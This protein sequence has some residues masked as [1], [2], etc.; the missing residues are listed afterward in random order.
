LRRFDTFHF[1]DRQGRRFD[2][3]PQR[4]LPAPFHLLA[5]FLGLRY[6]GVRDRLRIVRNVVS[7]AS[8]PG[9][10]GT[11][12]R[13]RSTLADSTIARWLVRH[14]ATAEAVG[15]FRTCSAQS[16]CRWSALLP[17]GLEPVGAAGSSGRTLRSPRPP[18][19]VCARYCNCQSSPSR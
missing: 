1:F 16:R 5:S 3:R 13:A 14:G 12:S 6:L 15:C 10:N 19:A 9:G 18:T 4:Y 17:R 11:S 7:L 2:V 8:L